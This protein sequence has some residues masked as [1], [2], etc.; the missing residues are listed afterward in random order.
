MNANRT[1]AQKRSDRAAQRQ[2]C[3]DVAKF[4]KFVA[5]AIRQLEAGRPILIIA[6]VVKD[7]CGDDPKFFSR[8]VQGPPNPPS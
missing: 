3:R 1:P 6:N 5:I 7:P 4:K 2:F 8:L